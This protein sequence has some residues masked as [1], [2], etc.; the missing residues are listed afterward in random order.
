MP[1]HQSAAWLLHL[2]SHDAF[3]TLVT[4]PFTQ[5]SV[6]AVCIPTKRLT[7]LLLPWAKQYPNQSGSTVSTNLS[8]GCTCFLYMC[9]S[10]FFLSTHPSPAHPAR[11]PCFLL[12]PTPHH[13][14][15]CLGPTTCSSHSLRQ[16]HCLVHTH[17]QALMCAWPLMLPGCCRCWDCSCCCSRC[18]PTAHAVVMRLGW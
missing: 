1:Q 12:R 13:P 11:T 16:H 17:M 8:R 2:Q 9:V 7:A 15:K 5:T 18:L 4:S 6:H 14:T 3:H 10:P